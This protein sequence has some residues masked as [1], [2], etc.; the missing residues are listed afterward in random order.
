MY[1]ALSKWP[2]VRMLKAARRVISPIYNISLIFCDGNHFLPRQQQ[3]KGLEMVFPQVCC[4]S[5]V[6]SVLCHVHTVV[7]GNVRSSPS[8]A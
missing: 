3:V 2:R 5:K 1:R 7:R 8:Y 6:V 4:D